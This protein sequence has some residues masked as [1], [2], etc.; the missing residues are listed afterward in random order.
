MFLKFYNRYFRILFNP[1]SFLGRKYK[2]A[3]VSA[4]FGTTWWCNSAKIALILA[5]FGTT[6]WCN[7]ATYLFF[8]AAFITCCSDGSPGLTKCSASVYFFDCSILTITVRARAW[9]RRRFVPTFA[10]C[11]TRGWRFRVIYFDRRLPRPELEK[12]YFY[13]VRQKNIY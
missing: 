4:V 7:I 9:R 5:T 11:W 3:L 1:I 12:G 2:I 6:W 13:S 8:C 10:L